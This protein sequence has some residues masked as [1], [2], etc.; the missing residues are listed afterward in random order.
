MGMVREVK[1]PKLNRLQYLNIDEAVGLRA[2]QSDH[3][4]R[5]VWPHDRARGREFGK[6]LEYRIL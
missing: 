4:D 5:D 1:E 6:G 2:G 3:T